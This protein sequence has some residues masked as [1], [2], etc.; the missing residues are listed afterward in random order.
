MDAPSYR[1]AR[2]Q[3]KRSIKESDYHM[4]CLPGSLRMNLRDSPCGGFR[5]NDCPLSLPLRKL[6]EINGIPS[7]QDFKNLPM[8]L[9]CGFVRLSVSLA[10]LCLCFDFL[11]ACK[12]LYNPLRRSVRLSVDFIPSYA[13]MTFGHYCSCPIAR[14][15]SAVY[16][17]LFVCLVCLFHLFCLSCL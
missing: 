16:P 7:F 11:V 13:L 4:T 2:T 12:R 9:N 14:N 5:R 6:E 10:Y 3:L 8:T 1:D 17:A 15:S